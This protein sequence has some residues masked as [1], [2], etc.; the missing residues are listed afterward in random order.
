[1]RKKILP[2]YIVLLAIVCLSYTNGAA[3]NDGDDFRSKL[4]KIKLEKL[5]NKLELDKSTE[6]FFIQKYKDFHKSIGGLNKKRGKIVKQIEKNLDN[7]E[8]L[9]TLINRMLD[10]EQEITTE[11]KNF[12]DDLKTF[13]T[14]KQI[15]QMIVF[16]KNFALELRKILKEYRRDKKMDKKQD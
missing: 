6:D 4:E 3:Q 2:I 13:L 5:V 9:D 11:R 16:E 8:S 10:V 14:T 12:A 7:N 1:M 15:A